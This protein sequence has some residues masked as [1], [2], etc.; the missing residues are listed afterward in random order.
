MVGKQVFP[1]PRKWLSKRSVSLITMRGV[2]IEGA[3]A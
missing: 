1:S 2:V 3:L